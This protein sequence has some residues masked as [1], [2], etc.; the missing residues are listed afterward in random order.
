MLAVG[1]L[2]CQRE[3]APAAGK[4]QTEAEKKTAAVQGDETR[5]DE[6]PAS[7]PTK[8]SERP[9]EK[10]KTIPVAEPVADQP[11]F[12]KSP[13]NGK[14]VDVKGIPSGT[15]VADPTYPAEEKK[16]FRIPEM[17]EAEEQIARDE[18]AEELAKQSAQEGKPVPGQANFIFSP[19]DNKIID[20]TGFE[21]GSVVKDPS[22][23]PGEPRYIKIPGEPAPTE[24]E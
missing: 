15:L 14:I 18:L 23:P 24:G 11:G 12:V 2:S 6:A 19:Y 13:F 17:P 20:V 9:T 3:E 22:S 1:S 10:K 4:P 16:Y 5:S 8:T 21:P 7:K